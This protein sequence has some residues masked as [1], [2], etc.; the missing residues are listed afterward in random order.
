[1][2]A[3]AL[4]LRL[5][6]VSAGAGGEEEEGE[7]EERGASGRVVGAEPGATRPRAP[8]Q[9]FTRVTGSWSLCPSGSCRT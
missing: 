5:L 4:L 8:M 2:T 6:H 1:M 7:E 3:P 9:E